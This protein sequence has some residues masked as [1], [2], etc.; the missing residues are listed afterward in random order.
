M[1]FEG[2]AN[3]ELGLHNAEVNTKPNSF[4]QTGMEV[5]TT[6]VEMQ[7]KQARQQASKHNCEL[8]LDAM[9]TIPP[10]EGSNAYLSAHERTRSVLAD[11]R[12][13]PQRGIAAHAGPA[14]QL[15]GDAPDT[16]GR[17]RRFCSRRG[18]IDPPHLRFRSPRRSPSTTTPRYGRSSDCSR[19]R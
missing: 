4:D 9:W 1:V 8:V 7:T 3:K 19:Y 13:P 14:A 10:E 15:D 16:A 2:E 5:Q 17:S 6:A 12:A 18:H 11:A